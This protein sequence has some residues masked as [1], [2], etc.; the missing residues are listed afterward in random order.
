VWSTECFPTL[1]FVKICLPKSR[2]SSGSKVKVNVPNGSDKVKIWDLL[3]GDMSLNRSWAMLQGKWIKYPQYS[4]ELY[5]SWAFIVFL[6][7]QSPWNH[8]PMDSKG[9]PYLYNLWSCSCWFLVLFFVVRENTWRAGGKSQLGE[10]LP[11]HKALSFKP[12]AGGRAR[13]DTWYDFDFLKN[14]LRLILLPSSW[15]MF[16]LV[17]YLFI[18]HF[19]TQIC[20]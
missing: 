12:S 3:E 7:W 15:R 2:W 18:C 10:S 4:T 9:L 1:N 19:S 6:Q 16:C 5:A 20:L 13:K 8:I 11:M 17:V 14:L